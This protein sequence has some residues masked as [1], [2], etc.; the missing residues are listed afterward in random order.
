[1][2]VRGGYAGKEYWAL[3][4]GGSSGLGWAT[5]KQLAAQGMNIAMVHRDRRSY[6]NSWR[7][8]WENLKK[9]WPVKTVRWNS[10]ALLEEKREEILSELLNRVG[11]QGHIRVF[12]HALSRGNL[13]KMTG[14][15]RLTSDD[16]S[17]TAYAMGT[18]YYE[19]AASLRAI[20]LFRSGSRCIGFTSAGNERVWPFYAAISVA[21]NVLESLS[22]SMAV[23]WGPEGIRSNLIQAGIT[24]T[25]SLRAIPGHNDLLERSA[26]NNPLGR[27]TRAEDVAKVVDLLCRT[28]ADWING[29]VIPVDGGETLL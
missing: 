11:K 28:E 10:N 29:A 4:L 17:H 25:P 5:V 12:V 23:E 16:I 9:Q 20:G 26:S 15:K 22:R 27:T 13:K 3:V 8:E 2:E 1:M 21:K 6:M 18:S 14:D 24:D 19:W 7:P